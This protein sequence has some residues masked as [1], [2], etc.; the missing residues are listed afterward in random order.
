MAAPIIY[1][2]KKFPIRLIHLELV[3]YLAL[4]FS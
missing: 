4:I 1:V 2:L 3:W